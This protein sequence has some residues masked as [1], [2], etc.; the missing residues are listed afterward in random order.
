MYPKK[1]IFAPHNSTTGRHTSEIT[2]GFFYARKHAAY[3][4]VPTLNGLGSPVEGLCNGKCT[5]FFFSVHT[6][7]NSTFMKNSNNATGGAQPEFKL[8]PNET[9]GANRLWGKTGAQREAAIVQIAV[10]VKNELSAM[11]MMAPEQFLIT[12]ELLIKRSMLIH[13][14]LFETETIGKACAADVVYCDWIIKREA[15]DTVIKLKALHYDMDLPVFVGASKCYMPVA[16]ETMKFV[17]ESAYGRIV[18]LVGEGG[19]HE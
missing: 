12:R 6:H 2:A 1:H 3:N 7:K 8:A 5:P 16:I 18:A 13:H 9:Y 11:E 15:G 10:F 14:F 4:P 19:S 17:D